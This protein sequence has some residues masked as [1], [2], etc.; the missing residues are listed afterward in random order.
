[1]LSS[2]LGILL[3]GSV[4]RTVARTKRNSVF[5]GVGA[6]FILTAYV[7]G[8]GAFALWLATIYGQI[9]AWLIIAGGALAL[10]AIILIVM[11]GLNAQEAQR[12]REKRVAME[13]AAGAAIG[14]LR[15]QPM[16]AVAIGGAFLL[17]NLM[18]S[19]KNDD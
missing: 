1:M 14:L 11:A 13:S 6:L 8:L 12:A 18:G 16:L 3:S 15:G 2:I 9:I 7:F 17:A 4:S 19:G 5:I 10:G